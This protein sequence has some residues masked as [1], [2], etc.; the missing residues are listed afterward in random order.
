MKY[1]KDTVNKSYFQVRLSKDKGGKAQEKENMR[2]WKQK[3]CKKN[4]GK[5]PP[6]NNL[7][8]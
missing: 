6:K 1:S 3:E 4:D 7:K 8:S 2:K 5:N